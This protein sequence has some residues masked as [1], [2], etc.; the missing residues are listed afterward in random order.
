M[1]GAPLLLPTILV[2]CSL[3][4]LAGCGESRPG[5]L[6]EEPAFSD[7]TPPGPELGRLYTV[8]EQKREGLRA[9]EGREGIL[10]EERLY[11]KFDEELII[12]DFFGDRRGGFFLDVG[13]AWAIRSSNTY[14]LEKHLGWKGIGIDALAEYGPSWAR[15]RPR[16]RFFSYL[17]TDQSGV[18]ETFFKSP[19]PGLSSTSKSMASGKI[20][21]EVLEPEVVRIETITLDD[22]L[23]REGVTKIDLLSMDIE[24]HEPFA[25][26]GFDIERFQPELAV[27]E[28]K[29][30]EVKD[31]ADD[32]QRYF[33]RHGYRLL[34]K[35]DRFDSVNRYFAR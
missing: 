8:I 9:V 26:A 35:Y 20:F 7:Q 32:V 17:V 23:D 24:G 13:C 16:S 30:V 3:S 22:L 29:V 31:G 1:I 10:A 34:E 18:V 33:E 21:G 6:Q 15:E 12:R 4:L 27:V 25:L 2:A 11:S 19:N 14:Y 5:S 28:R